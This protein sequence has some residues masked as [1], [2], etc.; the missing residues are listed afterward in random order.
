VFVRFS[1]LDY[2]AARSGA[3]LVRQSVQASLASLI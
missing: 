2:A 3:I 1:P